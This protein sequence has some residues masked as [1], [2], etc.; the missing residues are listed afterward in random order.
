MVKDA[1]LHRHNKDILK[2]K[3]LVFLSPQLEKRVLRGRN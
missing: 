1:A 3:H 2:Q